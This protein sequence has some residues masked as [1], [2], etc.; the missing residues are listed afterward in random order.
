MLAKYSSTMTRTTGPP[1]RFLSNLKRP[2]GF[3]QETVPHREALRELPSNATAH[4][5]PRGDWRQREKDPAGRSS[6]RAAS[7][8]NFFPPSFL[9]ELEGCC[10]DY[11]TGN[12]KAN[13]RDG[14]CTASTQY[15]TCKE[16]DA[17]TISTGGAENGGEGAPIQSLPDFHEAEGRPSGVLNTTT[18]TMD[19][20]SDTKIPEEEM[21]E[22]YSLDVY[23]YLKNLEQELLPDHL[24]MHRRPHIPSYMRSDLVDWL[25]ALAD[26][27]GLEDEK[28]FLAVSYID[29]FLSLTSVQRNCL[30]LLATTAL[31]TASKF[32]GGDQRRCSDLLFA[33]G[34][35]Y[36][37][38]D[39]LGM[40]RHMLKILNYDIGAP[41]VYFFLRCFAQVSQAPDRVRLLAQ[42]FCELALLDDDPYLR[43]PPSVIAGAALCLANHTLDR[44]P[45]GREL[46]EYS[47]YEVA[48]FQECLSFLQKSASHA[49][50]RSQQ[51][52]RNKFNA[53]KY[54]HVSSLKPSPSIPR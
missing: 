54:L 3:A 4:P 43:F 9:D 48:H 13:A 33:S 49:P 35:I 31:F 17:G 34:N 6:G 37:E 8:E 38:E 42:Y 32:E 53:T 50:S 5:P 52:V 47:G 29:R 14:P 46:A 23:N 44:Q 12:A 2:R 40:E 7:F 36:T 28:L 18:C 27:Y 16:D 21:S 39:V 15:A 10:N 51:A 1:T 45:W 24:Y 11:P 30:Q 41:T 22:Q 19:M 26:A 20:L 25:V